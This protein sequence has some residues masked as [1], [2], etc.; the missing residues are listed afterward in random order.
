MH[1]RLRWSGACTAQFQTEEGVS[2]LPAPGRWAAAPAA[3]AACEDGLVN[4]QV[5]C[6]LLEARGHRVTVA[7]NGQEAVNLV[8]RETFDLVLMDVNMPDMDGLEATAAIRQLEQTTGRRVPIIAMTANAMKGDRERCLGA[9]MD[10]Y[11][12]K[13]IRAKD[14]YATV[15]AVTPTAAPPEEAPATAS[16]P[17]GVLDWEAAVQRVGGRSDLLR[18]MVKVFLQECGKLMPAIRRAIDEGDGPVLR[19]LAHSLKGSADTFAAHAAVGAASRLETMGRDGE[20][21]DGGKAFDA[22]QREIDRLGP[23]LASRVL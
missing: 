4:Q 23:A 17:D 19:R 15:E 11:L 14:L 13:P 22:L 10:G 7:N 2:T 3:A 5:A 18:K 8:A 12:A 16:A 6:R 9:G 21:A 20:L 1:V